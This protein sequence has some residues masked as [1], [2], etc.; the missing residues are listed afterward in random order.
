MLPS[1]ALNQD[2]RFQKRVEYFATQQLVAQRE[3]KEADNGGKGDDQD[4]AKAAS[5]VR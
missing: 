5:L 2:L 4:Q 1:P 3:V